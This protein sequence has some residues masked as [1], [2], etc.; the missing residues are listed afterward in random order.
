MGRFRVCA[1]RSHST[2]RQKSSEIVRKKSRGGMA[3]GDLLRSPII[4]ASNSHEEHITARL[5]IPYAITK[6]HHSHPCNILGIGKSDYT[7]NSRAVNR[8]RLLYFRVL[9]MRKW[10]QMTRRQRRRRRR[11][12]QGAGS[13]A[14]TAAAIWATRRNSSRRVRQ[15]GRASVRPP[16]W[17]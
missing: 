7:D 1:V 8:Q 9:G 5:K 13:S 15:G 11:W 17:P 14:A 6:S 16:Q 2:A 4:A 10:Q 12:D 3:H